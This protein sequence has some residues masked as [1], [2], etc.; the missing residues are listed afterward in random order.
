MDPAIATP[1]IPFALPDSPAEG[2]LLG[3]YFRGLGDT[4]RVRILELLAEHA[5][6]SVGD[7]VTRLGQSQPK[8]SNHLGCLRWCGFVEAH[9]EHPSV[10][11]RL[12]DERV[13]QLLGLGRG[14][15]PTTWNTSPHAAASPRSPDLSRLRAATRPGVAA[16][17]SLTVG[18]RSM[19]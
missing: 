7:L 18:A 15:S 9:R 14:C 4:T 2:D 11:Y 10:H 3:K 12:A 16:V 1:A 5:E 6:L 13:R 17:G 19:A 8:V